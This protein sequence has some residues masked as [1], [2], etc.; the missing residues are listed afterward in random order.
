MLG[1]RLASRL[2]SFAGGQGGKPSVLQLAARAATVPG[3]TH[4]DLNYPDH[5]A[6]DPATLAARLRD[7]G[8]QVNGLAMRY[9]ANPAF[10]LGAFTHPEAAV[11]REAIDLTKRGVDAAMAMGAPLMTIWLGQDG[12]DTSFQAD[13]ARLWDDAVAALREVALHDPACSVSVEYKPNEPRAY[14]LLPDLGTTLLALSDVGAP[15]TGVTLDFAHLL[16]AGE[17][18][19]MAAAMASRRSRLLGVHLNDAH[20]HRDD[21]LMVGAVHLPATLELLWQL[22][23]DG[24]D[25]VLYFDTFPDASGLDPVAEASANVETVGRLLGIAR[26]LQGDAALDA[27]RAA[28]DA[29]AALR[30]VNR[31][32][33]GGA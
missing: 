2:N 16:Y 25:G 27:A 1:T 12:F 17:M 26:G 19:A 28:Q 23:R 7:L 31:A 15:N 14:A 3:L 29:A 9:Y 18:P 11:R 10:K 24:W 8:L 5:V 33:M 13:Y 21:G 6:G 32:L 30:I 20:G 4:V 22:L